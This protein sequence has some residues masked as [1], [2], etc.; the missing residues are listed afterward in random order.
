MLVFRTIEELIF[1]KDSEKILL[2]P[3]DI[4]IQE[5]NNYFFLDIVL[6]GEKISYY[7]FQKSRMILP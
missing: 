2:L 5:K 6:Q 4:I 7:I 1:F 3:S